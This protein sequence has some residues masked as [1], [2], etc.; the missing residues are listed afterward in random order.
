M[1]F[2]SI[3]G[4][5]FLTA[6]ALLLGANN[7][8]IGILASLPFLAMPLQILTVALVERSGRRKAIALPLWLLAQL[9]W[10]PIALIPIIVGVPSPGA[11]TLLLVFVAI[12]SSLA[13]LQNSAWNPWMRDLVPPTTMG[14]FF[15]RRLSLANVAAMVFGLGAAIFVDVWGGRTE[16]SNEVFGYTI[17]IIFGA[18]TLGSGSV[19]ARLFMPEPLMARSQHEE[20]TIVSALSGP[21]RDANFRGLIRFQFFWGF[22]LHLAVPFFAV[23]MLT[24]LDFPVTVVLGFAVLSQASNVLFLN[25]WGPMV[26]R[27]GAKPVLTMSVSLYLLVVIGWTFTTLPDK[28]LMTVPLLVVLHVLAG[29][30]SAGN[31]LTTGTIAFK[32]APP[33]ETTA[34]ASAASLATNLGAGLGPLVG[35]QFVDFFSERSLRLSF[36]WIDPDRV[37]ELRAL[38]LSGFDF[39]FAVTFIIGL[40][41]LGWLAL[42]REEGEGSTSEALRSLLGPL[43]RATAP[44]SSVPGA[45]LLNIP[46]SLARNVPGVDV[47]M[48]VTAYQLA[49]ATRAAA[50]AAT[51]GRRTTDSA[52]SA[53]EHGVAG[54]MHMAALPARHSVTAARHAARGVGIAAHESGRHLGRAL[55]GGLIGIA[56][57]M[58]NFP[59]IDPEVAYEAAV[60]G[61][62]EGALAAGAEPEDV[63]EALEDAAS[64]AAAA[65]GIDEIRALE[66]TAAVVDM[67]VTESDSDSPSSESSLPIGDA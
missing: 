37:V 15:A 38:S 61:A 10:V 66:I 58:N 21:F 51:R 1:G 6:F 8:E 20:R 28:H 39:L 47:A 49:E 22:A 34:Y 40:T 11:V 64:S 9:M 27:V 55:T 7:L 25:M 33:G 60:Y 42:I 43:Q 44:M 50:T 13:A 67:V 18:M 30:A 14:R 65:S 17:A 24:V 45:G 48:G 19:L 26:D 12:R 52:M 62:A 54:T 46:F 56:R 41:T 29:A 3:T 36:T 35:G 31:N 4:S 23:Y 16:D 32:L 63:A 5:G 2:G 59:S 57:G 53:I